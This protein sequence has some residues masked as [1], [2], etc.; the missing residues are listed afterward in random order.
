MSGRVVAIAGVG[1][2][3][4]L[5]GLWFA[6]AD[7]DAAA[8]VV[9]RDRP[10]PAAPSTSPQASRAQPASRTRVGTGVPTMRRPTSSD[11]APS[12]EAPTILEAPEPAPETKPAR[13]KP[14]LYR[15]LRDQVRDTEP[16]VAECNEIAQKAGHKLDGL[17]AFKFTLGRDG[18]KTVIVSTDIEYNNIEPKA[19]ECIR[20]TARRM[21]FDKLPEGVQ[22]VTAYRK[23]TFKDG[24]LM[25]N[26]L[27]F[28]ATDPPT[29][30]PYD[31]DPPAPPA[32]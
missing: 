15:S 27:S 7:D 8:P 17:S 32:P 4:A 21:T 22:T 30:T 20:E 1:V 12:S 2:L 10:Q 5:A 19:A 31:A 18:D 14:P 9:T 23:T 28:Y 26:W 3:A 16:W 29:P 25:E 13:I 11:P 24:V 6:V